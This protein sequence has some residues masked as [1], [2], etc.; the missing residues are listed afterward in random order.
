MDLWTGVCFEL[1]CLQ[2]WGKASSLFLVLWELMGYTCK[3]D[4]TAR[5][6]LIVFGRLGSLGD[7]PDDGNKANV[8]SVFKKKDLGQC[9]PA[10]FTLV[11]GKV[12]EKILLEA[13]SMQMKDKNVVRNSQCGFVKG[14]SC[15]TILTAFYLEVTGLVVKREQWL[16]LL[17]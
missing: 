15:W 11:L 10:S 13:I 8:T 7:V 12:V 3:A 9:K 1:A 5:P 14:N 16:L 4:V 17:L 2:V 6:L